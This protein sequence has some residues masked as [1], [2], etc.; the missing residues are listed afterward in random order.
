MAAL[1]VVKCVRLDNVV[2]ESERML[3]EKVL[4]LVVLCDAE[5]IHWAN[6]SAAVIAGCMVGI[7]KLQALHMSIFNV[8]MMSNRKLS[9]SCHYST[10][11]DDSHS[12]LSKVI[13]VS[14][15]GSNMALHVK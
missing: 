1:I 12:W 11:H 8:A 7:T 4:M 9:N 14:G 15:T 13:G 3:I 10:W 6:K 5:L 2:V